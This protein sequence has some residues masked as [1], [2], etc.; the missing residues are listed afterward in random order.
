MRKRAF[1]G[2]RAS[3]PRSPAI[4]GVVLGGLVVIVLVQLS[5]DAATHVVIGRNLAALQPVIETNDLDGAREHLSRVFGREVRPE[6]IGI[7]LDPTGK[8]WI[9]TVPSTW[10]LDLGVWRWERTVVLTGTTHRQPE[11][12]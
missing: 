3:R 8:R 10:D 5:G 2:E 11:G 6:E 1:R 7:E 9:V 4:R 12:L